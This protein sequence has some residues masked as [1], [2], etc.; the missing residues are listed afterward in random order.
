MSEIEKA[1]YVDGYNHKL[2]QGSQA[3]PKLLCNKSF[4]I[5]RWKTPTTAE[6][7][8][9]Y[10]TWKSGVVTKIWNL[11]PSFLVTR[12][13]KIPVGCKSISLTKFSEDFSW[14][15]DELELD[16]VAPGATDATIHSI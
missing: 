5:I 16:F 6:G 10:A 8:L 12:T 15:R 11:E 13:V 1:K 3:L 4:I 9:R 7:Y 14:G 2:V